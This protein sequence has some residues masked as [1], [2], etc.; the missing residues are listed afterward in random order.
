MVKA[1]V[2]LRH[3]VSQELATVLY[4]I[5][6][7]VVIKYDESGNEM[8]YHLMLFEKTFEVILEIS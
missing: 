8:T 2:K 3:K 7:D 6:K 5:D 4:V 1:G